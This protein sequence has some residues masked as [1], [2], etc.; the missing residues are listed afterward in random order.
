MESKIQANPYIFKDSSTEDKLSNKLTGETILCGETI[1]ELINFLKE[2]KEFNLIEEKFYEI[3]DELPQLI[4]TLL[5]KKFLF[6]EN[7][8]EDSVTAIRPCAPHLFNLPFLSKQKLHNLNK[9]AIVFVGVPFGMGN[10]INTTSAYYP[11]SLRNYT[12]KYRIKLDRDSVFNTNAIGFDNEFQTLK[13]IK[14]EGRLFDNG[15]IFFDS[16]ESL[17]F[18]YD[19]I[20]KISKVLFEDSANQIPF[21]IGGDHSISYPIIKSA[22]EKFGDDLCVIHFDAHTDTYDSPYSKINHHKKNHHHGNF[23]TECFKA[24]LKQVYQFG[25]RG[26][27]NCN[28]DENEFQTIYWCNQTKKLIQENHAF[29][30]LPKNKKYYVTFDFDVLDPQFFNGTSTPV[31]N[32]FTLEECTSLIKLV[33]KD[34][35]VIGLDVVELYTDKNDLELTHQVAS[36]FIFNLLN[37]IS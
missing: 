34:K 26:L 6:K 25:I 12:Q 4:H 37:A 2:P 16:N 3:K 5:A 9:K 10:K 21:F 7:D 31:I 28:Q 23:L 18:C 36:Q 22:L 24:G 29:D 30:E 14:E 15:N 19:K 35:E 27:V 8:V 11:N 32:G 13:Q 1:I 20:G 17:T 33:L